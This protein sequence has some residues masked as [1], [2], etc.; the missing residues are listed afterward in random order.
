MQKTNNI[1]LE[2]QKQIQLE[3]ELNAAKARGL[4]ADIARLQQAI[5]NSKK[6]QELYVQ[7]RDKAIEV[8]KQETAAR[9]ETYGE[10]FANATYFSEARVKLGEEEYDALEGLIRATK[11]VDS[12]VVSQIIENHIFLTSE[13]IATLIN[14]N[15]TE[16]ELLEAAVD[17]DR[18]TL[19]E[20]LGYIKQYGISNVEIKKSILTSEK[21]VNTQGLVDF[22][23]K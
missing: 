9:L 8:M 5:E 18:D 4:P 1:N 12:E 23:V 17:L 10:N 14:Y 11:D 15:I 16:K 6:Q 21:V 19:N 2:T 13:K 20:R 3:N 7:D 22:T